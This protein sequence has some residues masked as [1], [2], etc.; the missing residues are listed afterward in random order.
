MD[1]LAPDLAVVRC[2][3]SR[4]SKLLSREVLNS[5]A[6]LVVKGYCRKVFNR[7]DNLPGEKPSKLSERF[8]THRDSTRIGS[9][10]DWF[11][12]LRVSLLLSGESNIDD[13]LMEMEWFSRQTHLGASPWNK[14]QHSRE[15]FLASPP[16]SCYGRRKSSLVSVVRGFNVVRQGG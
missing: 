5:R 12:G 1:V 3:W 2:A 16:A 4:A 15:I 14:A 6:S 13:Y 7:T 8:A 10:A 11:H 9:S